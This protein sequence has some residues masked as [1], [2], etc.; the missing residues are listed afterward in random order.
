HERGVLADTSGEGNRI[1]VPQDQ[2]VRTDEATQL[3]NVDLV[4]QAA[5]VIALVHQLPDL[6]EIIDPR[7]ALPNGVPVEEVIDFVDLHAASACQVEDHTRV[8]VTGTG[9]HDQTSQ[10]GQAHGGVDR[11]AAADR[12]SRSTV[13]QVQG[14]LVD[15]LRLA[16]HDLRHRAG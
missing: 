10:R 1:R 9:A 13:A 8:D 16:A 14:D 5:I 15:L 11:L 3:M 12:R 7:D 2:H 6:A 4:G